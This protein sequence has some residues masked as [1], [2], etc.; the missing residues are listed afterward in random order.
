[1]KQY[2]EREKYD[3]INEAYIESQL[4]HRKEFGKLADAYIELKAKGEEQKRRHDDKIGKMRSICLAILGF[5]CLA[6]FVYYLN[7]GR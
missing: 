4:K 6:I 1:M 7:V 3:E 5:I 2:C